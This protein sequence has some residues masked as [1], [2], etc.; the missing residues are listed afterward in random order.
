MKQIS[1]PLLSS[2]SNLSLIIDLSSILKHNVILYESYLH[3]S[4]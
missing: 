1:F 3:I 4:L 2:P